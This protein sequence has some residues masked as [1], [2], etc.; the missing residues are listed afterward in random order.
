MISQNYKNQSSFVPLPFFFFQP[1]GEKVEGT[2]D[3]I[4]FT[5]CLV[6]TLDLVAPLMVA[7]GVLQLAFQ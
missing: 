3:V 7:T 4:T 1:E 5:L 6:L 2:V